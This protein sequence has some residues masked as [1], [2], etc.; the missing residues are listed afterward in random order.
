MADLD[1]MSAMIGEIRADMRHAMKW[2]D[3]HEKADQR[4]F[5]ALA[6]RL[7]AADFV[8]TKVRIDMVEQN[9]SQIMPVVEGVSKAKWAA[10]GFVAAVSLVGGFIGGKIT[11]A[12]TS[13]MKLLG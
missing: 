3:E 10:I 13:M 6:E 5:A 2:F 8:R 12:F 9:I 4:R 11:T 7:D 1:E